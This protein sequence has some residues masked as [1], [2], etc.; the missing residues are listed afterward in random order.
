MSSRSTIRRSLRRAT[1]RAITST[2]GRQPFG[3]ISEF[4]NDRCAFSTS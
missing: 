1:L 2:D 4:M 3:K